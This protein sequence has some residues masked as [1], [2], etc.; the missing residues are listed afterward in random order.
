MF[1]TSGKIRVLM[2]DQDTEAVNTA[3]LGFQIRWPECTVI[4][5]RKGE[6]GIQMAESELPHMIV[7][8]INLL[9]ISGFE[10]IKRIRL[11]SDVPIMVL[12]DR[13]EEMDVVKAL[14]IGADDYVT[15]PFS[16]LDLLA[17]AKAILRRINMYQSEGE[18][19]PPFVTNDLIVDFATRQVFHSGKLVHLTPIE[20]R[21]LCQLVR[22]APKVV[23]IKMLKQQVWGD[24]DYLEPSTIRKSVSQLRQK[25]GG[26]SDNGHSILNERGLG[27]KFIGARV[28][29]GTASMLKG[30]SE[31]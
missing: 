28:S 14:E 31:D 13:T 17:R 7:M 4:S 12:S 25:I 3:S 20:Y 1:N 27:Y 23:S 9:D 2:I 22:N 8:E 21:I 5:T 6:K 10:V 15:K 16:T 29:K 19:L 24:V 18:D 11:F 26:D 30:V